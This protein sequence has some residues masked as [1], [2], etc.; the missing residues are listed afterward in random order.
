MAAPPE[1]RR[2]W[3]L[4][5]RWRFRTQRAPHPATF[6]APGIAIPVPLIKPRAATLSSSPKRDRAAYTST[7]NS[8]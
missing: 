8:P 1:K 6:L 5:L 2:R 7:A 3:P 4:S